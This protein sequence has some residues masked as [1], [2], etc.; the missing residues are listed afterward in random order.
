MVHLADAAHPTGHTSLPQVDAR[1]SKET[2]PPWEVFVLCFSLLQVQA[3][4]WGLQYMGRMVFGFPH[5]VAPGICCPPSWPWVHAKLPS[6]KWRHSSGSFHTHPDGVDHPFSSTHHPSL[7]ITYLTLSRATENRPCRVT[8]P[9]V[10]S[11]A[12]SQQKVPPSKKALKKL[13]CYDYLYGVYGGG[14]CM[15]RGWRTNHDFILSLYHVGPRVLIQVIRKAAS[16][17]TQ[18]AISPFIHPQKY[19]VF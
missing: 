4:G 7:C 18:W 11:S 8:T 9:S 6:G 2:S 16:T 1:F 12:F 3:Q 15:C 14:E 17:F 10:D 13:L 5:Q 19:F